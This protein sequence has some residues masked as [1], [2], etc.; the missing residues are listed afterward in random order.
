VTRLPVVG[1]FRF[2]ASAWFGWAQDH[3]PNTWRIGLTLASVGSI[4]VAA[5]GG[6]LTWQHRSDGS[7]LTRTTPPGPA[8]IEQGFERLVER[9]GEGG[10]CAPPTRRPGQTWSRSVTR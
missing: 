5:L 7:A 9:Y 3:P 10:V 2:F 8:A 6:V 4:L 1:V